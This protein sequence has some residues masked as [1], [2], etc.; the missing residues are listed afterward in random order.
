MSSVANE[1]TSRITNKSWLKIK[2]CEPVKKD[3]TGNN[4]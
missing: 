2:L 4:A 3:L 1:K